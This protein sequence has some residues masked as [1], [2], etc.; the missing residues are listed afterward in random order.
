MNS[1]PSTHKAF[2]TISLLQTLCNSGNRG[3]CLVGQQSVLAGGGANR[4]LLSSEAAT[5]CKA[6]PGSFTEARP[7]R[8]LIDNLLVRIHFI[9]VMIRWTGLAPWEFH[10]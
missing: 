10:Y 5:L 2:G 8:V 1:Q 7:L 9:I 3:G 6:F 4:R